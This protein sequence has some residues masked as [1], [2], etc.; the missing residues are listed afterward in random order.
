MINSMVLKQDLTARN[1]E[2]SF[3]TMINSMVLKRHRKMWQWNVFWNN[4]KQHGVKTLRLQYMLFQSFWNND[5][6]NGIK[7]RLNN[8]LSH[9]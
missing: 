8:L 4:D 5:K 2:I 3:G 1:N 7:T 9:L 6:Q